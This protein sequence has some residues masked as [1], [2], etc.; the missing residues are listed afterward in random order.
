MDNRLFVAYCFDDAY[1]M[2]TLASTTSLL[3][4]TPSAIIFLFYR[5]AQPLNLKFLEFAIRH[6]HPTADL[7]FRNLKGYDWA[8]ENHGS[9]LLH[10]SP[11]SNDRLV[12]SEILEKTDPDV[13]RLLYLDGDTIV[14]SDLSIFVKDLKLPKSGVGARRYGSIRS[15]VWGHGAAGG[16]SLSRS[17]PALNA[18]VL[19]LDLNLLRTNNFPKFCQDILRNHPSNDQALFNLYCHGCFARLPVEINMFVS[20]T[21]KPWF[22][23]PQILHCAGKSF[24]FWASPETERLNRYGAL[25]RRLLPTPQLHKIFAIKAEEHKNDT[26]CY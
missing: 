7:R 26:L 3:N 16:S 10:T 2:P 6:V 12:I 18:G 4:K 17:T 19:V 24:K 25:W 14:F 20:E 1:V 11:C 13:T 22:G 9:H 15:K 8:S 23:P 5:L 21:D